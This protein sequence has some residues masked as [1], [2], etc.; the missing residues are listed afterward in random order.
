MV[1]LFKLR[2]PVDSMNILYFIPS[3]SKRDG[4][5][6]H[7]SIALL[8][9][10]ASYLSTELKYQIYSPLDH[11]SDNFFINARHQFGFDYKFN[12]NHTIG[13]YYLIN[14]EFN[15]KNPENIHVIG[16]EWNI[17]LTKK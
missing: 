4:G 13:L 17:P 12:S 7:Y 3:L 5:I 10:I 8:K 2:L 9:N 1:D 16:L 6:Y 14:D 15:I 11:V